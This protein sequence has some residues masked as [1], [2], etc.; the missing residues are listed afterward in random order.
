[1][2]YY[3][4]ICEMQTSIG[5]QMLISIILACSGQNLKVRTTFSESQQGYSLRKYF[6]TTKMVLLHVAY[7]SLLYRGGN[8]F[9]RFKFRYLAI[10]PRFQHQNV[11]Q[12]RAF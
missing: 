7:T 5:L 12:L 2:N 4:K 1:M 9:I 11:T 10:F 3:N 8:N 6:V